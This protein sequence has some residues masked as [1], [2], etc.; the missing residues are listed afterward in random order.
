MA[1]PCCRDSFSTQPSAVPL[2]FWGGKRVSYASPNAASRYP[3]AR[4][5]RAPAQ[6][7][8]ASR[9]Q[10]RQRSDASAAD[11]GA[12]FRARH[13][14]LGSDRAAAP[15]VMGVSS[16]TLLPYQLDALSAIAED[17][18]RG[19]RRLLVVLPT[20]CGKTIIFAAYLGQRVGRV[21]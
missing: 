9:E 20:G 21:L 19:E 7:D 16:I 2:F 6:S 3:R 17:V 14:C 8:R 12:R 1:H 5:A 11:V 10:P 13:P 15:R 4:P 18:A